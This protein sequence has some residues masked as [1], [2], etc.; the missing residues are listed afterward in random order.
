MSG[1][2]R[3]TYTMSARRTHGEGARNPRLVMHAD[4]VAPRSA[5]DIVSWDA[6]TD[7]LVVGGGCAGVC[8]A[9]EALS[10]GARVLLLERAGEAGG[11][12][13]MSG[14]LLY[15]GAGTA[16]QRD[17][18]FEDTPEEMYKFLE[19]AMGP[20][21]DVDR[22]ATYSEGSVAHFDWLV[23]HGV[24]F[25]HSFWDRP[26]WTP[27]TDDGLMWVGENSHPFSELARPVPRGHR[28]HGTG[29][30]GGVLMDALSRA[31]RTAGAEVRFNSRA[32]QLVTAADGTVIGVVARH[33][34]EEFT[35]RA[36]GGVVL[37]AG[38]FVF[39]DD[40]LQAHAPHLI[41]HT[42]LGTDYD[43]GRAIRMAEA[44][45]AQTA[46]MDAGEASINFSPELMA[47]SV[48]VNVTG[49]RFINEDTYGGRIGQQVLFHQ[50]GRAYLVFD[51]EAYESVPEELRHGRFP[52]WVCP[53]LN[54]LEDEIGLPQRSLQATVEVFNHHAAS[55]EDPL[56][57]KNPRWL[58]PLCS[59]FAAMDVRA[60]RADGPPDTADR[61]TGFR[62]FTLGGLRTT[63]DGAVIHLDSTPIPGLFAAG[64]TACGLS[65][66]GYI[67][68]TSLGDGT[69]FGRRAGAAAAARL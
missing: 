6:D 47:K 5:E 1:R 60:R 16:V 24:P 64:R 57:R 69:F 38:G 56:F 59:P 63:V 12:S 15:L 11:A 45:G 31:M 53:T 52:Q 30:T 58:R 33:H 7:V 41:N 13:A 54:E 39:N 48:M 17:C 62:V 14:G 19:A 25:K 18:G 34:G 28:P 65:A 27:P 20:E 44:I 32:Q 3:T 10:R 29:R 23:G 8:A 49:Q 66:W 50:G 42:K 61:G 35:I 2:L 68:G 46:R 36:R 67:S 9:L 21:P 22:I 55:G 4:P 51:E 26:A 43:D 37:A 40:M